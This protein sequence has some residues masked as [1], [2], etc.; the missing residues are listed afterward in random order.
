MYPVLCISTMLLALRRALLISYGILFLQ[1]VS[2][3][4]PVG[5][6]H[7]GADHRVFDAKRI[8]TFKVW[9]T[10]DH[11]RSE[12]GIRTEWGFRA[13]SYI[14]NSSEMKLKQTSESV[15]ILIKT[16]TIQCTEYSVQYIHGVGLWQTSR[17]QTNFT[18]SILITA[19]YS[20]QQSEYISYIL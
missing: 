9:W 19:L 8:C 15:Y 20:A 12:Y 10:V 2:C 1:L 14:A 5:L 4:Y 3:E 11:G 17:M 16:Y 6:W 7:H 18:T 13:S